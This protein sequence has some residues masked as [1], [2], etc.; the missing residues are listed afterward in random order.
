M[1]VSS[2]PCNVGI[3]RLAA[4]ILA[5]GLIVPSAAMSA[6]VQH[7]EQIFH[8]RCAMCH[9]TEPGVNK[10]GPSLA[11][12]VGRKAGTVPNFNFSPALK[13]S[14]IVW[15][16]EALNK[17][18]TNP[19]SDV[20]GNRMPFPGLPSKSDRADIIAYLESIGHH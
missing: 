13:S 16:P 5:A 14:G 12:I 3:F 8:S 2:A 19:H 17:W 1:G 20:P 9:S 6:D 15:T 11:E 7:G 18:L 10:L 4:A